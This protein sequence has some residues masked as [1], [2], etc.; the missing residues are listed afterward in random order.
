M[1]DND[2]DDHEWKGGFHKP[3]KADLVPPGLCDPHGHHVGRS[4]NNGAVS[5]ETRAQR[6]CPPEGIF[7]SL[8]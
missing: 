2:G 4:P 7:R 6:Q 1:G 5:A 8:G 3:D